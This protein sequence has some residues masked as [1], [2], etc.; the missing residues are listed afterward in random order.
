M[1][2]KNKVNL[3]GKRKKKKGKV[4]IHELIITY[5]FPKEVY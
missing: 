3:Q 1:K 4:R 5:V 2:I